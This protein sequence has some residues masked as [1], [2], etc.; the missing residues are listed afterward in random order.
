[1]KR[2]LV[3]LLTFAIGIFAF[4]LLNLKYFSKSE[5]VE[6]V[7]N[8]N[9]KFIPVASITPFSQ[10]P[11]ELPQNFETENNLSFFNS[12]K[13]DE[14]YDGW[15]SPDDFKGMPE[16]STIILAKDS[17]NSKNENLIWQAMILRNDIDYNAIDDNDADLSSVWIK[18]ENN[19]LSFK[20]KKYRNVEYKFKGEF[21]RNG[22][23]FS[24]EEKVLKGNLQKFVKGKKVAEFT[25][26][27]AYFEPRCFH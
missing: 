20:T 4:G 2:L 22:K 18:T 16:V 19:K 10:P 14:G 12:F 7:P 3:A 13:D 15:F 25:S 23:N 17:W 26:D 11:F 1:M 24:E 8:I 6:T 5:K 9:S 21:L 27:F